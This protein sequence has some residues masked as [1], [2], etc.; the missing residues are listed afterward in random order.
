MGLKEFQ[1]ETVKSIFEALDKPA[2]D[3]ILKS[4]TESGKTTIC[5]NTFCFFANII[6]SCSRNI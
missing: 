3:T 5:T 4:P 1:L 6:E 2:C